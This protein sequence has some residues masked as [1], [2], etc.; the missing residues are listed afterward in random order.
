VQFPHDKHIDIVSGEGDPSYTPSKGEESCAVCHR[1]YQSQRKSADEV[2]TK[3]PA[4]LGDAFWLKKGSFKTAPIDHT[5]CFSCHSQESGLE[6]SPVNCAACHKLRQPV[7]ADFDPQ[8]AAKMSITDRVILRSWRHRISAGT[9]RHEFD[10]HAGM[11]CSTCH[12]VVNMNTADAKTKTVP[13][14]SCATCHATAKLDD[15]GVL[16]YEVDK[17][18]KDATFQCV[19]CHISFGKLP[20]PESHLKALEA[21][22]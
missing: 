13:V 15:G 18:Q 6:P 21:A 1:T 14:A 22:K 10:M 3:P 19:K 12:T 8:L 9:F 4:N 20:I 11:D 17:R 16:N 2:F 5:T 7:S